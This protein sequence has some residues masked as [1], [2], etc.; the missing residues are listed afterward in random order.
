MS[1][2]SAKRV[3]NAMAQG[4]GDVDAI[5]RRLGLEQISDTGALEVI[6][7]KIIE[8]NAAQVAEYRAGKDKVHAFFVGQAMKASKGRANPQ[9]LND[10]LKK[11]LSR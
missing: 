7:D 11:K 10:I 1:K 3:F 6:V 9:Q 2:L 5:I 4:E 8:S